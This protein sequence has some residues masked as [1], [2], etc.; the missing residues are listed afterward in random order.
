VVAGVRDPAQRAAVAELG[1]AQV[2]GHEEVGDHGPY[3]VIIELVGADSLATTL[4]ALATGGRAVV[5]GVGTGGRLDLDL[6][7]LM[8][9]RAHL[10]GSTLRARSRAEKAMVTAEV[11]RVLLPLIAGGRVRVPVFQTLA[12]SDAG[13]AYELFAAGGKFGKIVLVA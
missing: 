6:Q 7:L 11:E 10:R 2:V 5:I 9:K 13:R 3:D 4:P 12:M 8:S 1:A